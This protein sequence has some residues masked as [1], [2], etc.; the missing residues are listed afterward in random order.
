MNVMDYEQAKKVGLSKEEVDLIPNLNTGSIVELM[1]SHPESIEYIKS[2]Q[3]TFLEY[4]C[5]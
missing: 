5:F 4:H 2:M 1:I 3:N